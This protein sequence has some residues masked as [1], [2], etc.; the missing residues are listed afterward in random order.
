MANKE[1]EASKKVTIKKEAQNN[2]SNE[3]DD[4]NDGKQ[5]GGSDGEE[6]ELDAKTRRLKKNR[7]SARESRLRKKNYMER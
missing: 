7:D 2:E 4:L 3:E 5:G 1:K 6:D